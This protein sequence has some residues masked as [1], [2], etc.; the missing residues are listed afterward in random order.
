MQAF[1]QDRGVAVSLGFRHRTHMVYAETAW[2]MDDRSATPD[3]G[4]PIPMLSTAMGRAWLCHAS[5]I[6]RQKVLSQLRLE[7]PQDYARFAAALENA[8]HEF[9][10]N[11]Y[12]SS[13][14]DCYPD[15]YG[16]AVPLSKEVDG[17]SFVMNCGVL[18]TQHTFEEARKLVAVPLRSL[19]REIE[20]AIGTRSDS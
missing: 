5:A 2:R 19:V 20:I 9:G 4:A 16:F 12:C 8:S 1:S 13:R 10:I 3:T 14:G 15:V 7:Q 17:S 6:E 11:G 18:A